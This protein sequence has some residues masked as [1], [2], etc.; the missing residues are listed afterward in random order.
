MTG[1]ADKVFISFFMTLQLDANSCMVQVV[2]TISAK[3]AIGPSCHSWGYI[4]NSK[5]K[6]N[7]A[8]KS[9]AKEHPN[10]AFSRRPDLRKFRLSLFEEV[11]SENQ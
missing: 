2:A 4:H 8:V 5:E 3:A 1:V 6:G 9:L 7:I 11:E 10:K